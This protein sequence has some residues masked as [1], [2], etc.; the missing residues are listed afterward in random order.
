MLQRGFVL[1]LVGLG[2]GAIAL[3]FQ[4]HREKLRRGQGLVAEMDAQRQAAARQGKE[5]EDE[6][7]LVDEALAAIRARDAHRQTS[8][9]S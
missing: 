7:A 5:V 9:S 8:A 1:G 6:E 3:G 2:G 4:V